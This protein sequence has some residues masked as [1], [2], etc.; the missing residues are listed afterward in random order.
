MNFQK[1]FFYFKRNVLDYRLISKFQ[2]K[3]KDNQV[4]FNQFDKTKSLFVHIPKTGGS[5]IIKH[6]YQTQN[7]GHHS[8]SFYEKIYGELLFNQYFKFAIVRNPY[9]RLYSAY[10][11]LSKGGGSSKDEA[12]A[13]Q[14]GIDKLSFEDFVEEWISPERIYLG[15]HLVPQTFYITDTNDNVIIDYVGY[16]ENLNNDFD[17]IKMRL[18]NIGDALKLYNTSARKS[19]YK[20]VYTK[21]MFDKVYHIYRLDFK[22]L[23]YKREV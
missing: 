1:Q 21:S 2:A 5:A 13:R 11:Y 15:L 8:A 23:G 12:F 20:E 6:L 3:R 10:A 7:V 19:S 9:D 17:L 14:H 18:G 4:L 16:F 22:L